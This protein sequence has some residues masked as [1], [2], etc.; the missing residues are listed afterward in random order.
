M[1]SSTLTTPPPPPKIH[2]HVNTSS[3]A[4]DVTTHLIA[5]FIQRLKYDNSGT[6]NWKN[7]QGKRRV[8]HH[9]SND[10][11]GQRGSGDIKPDCLKGKMVCK[12]LH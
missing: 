10:V 8:S 5:E 1:A 6:V 11:S 9:L 2:L 7:E 12:S 3:F 4:F